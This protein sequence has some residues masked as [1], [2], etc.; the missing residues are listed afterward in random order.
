MKNGKGE[1]ALKERA[2]GGGGLINVLP[3]KKKGGRLLQREVN[4]GF[5]VVLCKCLR[6]LVGIDQRGI[7]QLELLRSFGHCAH[8]HLQ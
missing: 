1:G 5:T 2:G 3:L 7:D 6:Q 8:F 4:R